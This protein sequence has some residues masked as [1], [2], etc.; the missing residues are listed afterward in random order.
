[1]VLLHLEGQTAQLQ[2]MQGP[3]GLQGTM[4][5]S[6]CMKAKPCTQVLGFESPHW[7]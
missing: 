5:M 6:S 7:S 3:S 2:Y 1:M 4:N